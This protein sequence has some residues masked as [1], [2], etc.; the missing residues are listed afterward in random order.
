MLNNLKTV[1]G[2][3]LFLLIGLA[4]WGCNQPT[5]TQPMRGGEETGSLALPAGYLGDRT[6]AAE[7]FL[8]PPPAAG[9]DEEREEL[10]I[11]H[12]TRALAGSARWEMAAQD[13]AFN[14]WPTFSCALD[15]KLT[16]DDVPLTSRLIRRTM[17]DV[18]P[19]I[20]REKNYYH[21]PRPYTVAEGDTCVST[22]NLS[23]NGSY[24][25]GHATAGWTW[26]LILA[27]LVPDR[28]GQIIGRGRA[29]GESRVICGVHYPSDVVAG[30]TIATAVMTALQSDPDFIA[31]RKAARAE[32][33]AALA[34]A[35]DPDAARCNAESKQVRQRPW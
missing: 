15:A 2:P 18:G 16:P 34:A 24:P 23:A 26:T 7:D 9:S 22:I 5:S 12:D 19:I 28:A 27:E 1:A 29:F 13:A 3:L 35:P 4:S 17:A 8:P 14:M 10:K 11:F 32:L 25:S 33:D 20:S 31:D 6:P 30:Q 21:R